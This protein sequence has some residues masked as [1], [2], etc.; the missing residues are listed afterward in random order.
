MNKAAKGEISPEAGIIKEPT[1]LPGHLSHFFE[2]YKN[3]KRIFFTNMK[4]RRVK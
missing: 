1:Y 3:I 2:S 4:I